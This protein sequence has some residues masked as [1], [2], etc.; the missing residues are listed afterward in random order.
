ML[1]IFYHQTALPFLR[2][3]SLHR[4]SLSGYGAPA[5]CSFLFSVVH[6]YFH[7]CCYALAATLFSLPLPSTFLHPFFLLSLFLPS[8]C[9]SLYNV[10][11]SCARV[12]VFGMSFYPLLFLFSLSP[13]PPSVFHHRDIL[14]T[15]F[16]F[17]LFSFHRSFLPL[18]LLH[19][20]YG[21]FYIILFAATF[22]SA[23]TL[24]DWS[25]LPLTSSIFFYFLFFY[26][27]YF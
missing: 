12:P 14:F 18:H 26:L 15:S 21:I 25:F 11:P 13:P 24:P 10:I 23:P 5:T 2:C 3:S 9:F 19:L 16:P 8:F 17:L 4:C 1:S 7:H 6:T 20:I 22:S 27:L